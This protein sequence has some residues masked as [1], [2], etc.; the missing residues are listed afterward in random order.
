M[1]KNNKLMKWLIIVVVVLLAIAVIGKKAGWFGGQEKKQVVVEQVEKRD[2]TEIVSASGKIQPEV[3]VK[4][5]P[6][7][8]GE[9]VELN[10]KEGD[11][12]KKGQLLVRILPDIYQSYLDRSVATLNA[13]KANSENAKSR[14]VQAKSQFEK[15]K[16]T[17]DRNKKLFD[18]KLISAS[19][20]ETVK[21]AFEV[22]KAEV[23][24]A[25]QSLS[26]ADFNIRSAEASVKEAQ[27]N[28]RKTSIFAPVDGTI[29]KLN[30]EKGERVVGTSQMA[31]TEMMTL[32]NLN[33]MEVNVDVNE[34]DIVRVNVGDTANIEVDAYL[35]KKFKGVVTEVANSANISGL[36]VDQVTNFTVKVRILR[37]SYEQILDPEHPSRSVFN[38]G[39]SA[40][41]DIMTKKARGVLS[42]PIQAVTTRDTTV[43]GGG[44]MNENGDEMQDE[45]AVR[46]KN[47]KEDKAKTPVE[48]KEVECV[49]VVENESVKLVPVEIGIQ[50]NNYIEIKK[51]LTSSQKVVSAPYS[52]IAKLLKS[53]DA[54]EVV[55]KEQLYSKD[56]K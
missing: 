41:V 39:M 17:Y 54:I 22:A 40:T 12:V 44:K 15:A 38:P 8:S 21:S 3:E 25:E 13:T 49:F 6:D 32:A 4:I 5:S 51:G 23:D 29:S 11:R 31:G 36:S 50:D 2:I 33:E 42:V 52:A 27:D 53:G 19:D 26:G 46:V 35:G 20:W 10:V 24:A 37:E 30:I 7:V 9:I 28:L 18:E 34:N 56:K 48:S 43:G 55:K 1:A 45:E 47:E 14:I 16:L